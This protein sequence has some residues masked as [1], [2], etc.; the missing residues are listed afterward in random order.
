MSYTLDISLALGGSK[1]GL[2]LNAQLVDSSLAN[3]GSAISSGFYEVGNG[4]YLW[5]YS[6]FPDNFRG[7][8]KFYQQGQS[9]TILTFVSINPQDAENLDMKISNVSS[10]SGSG[11]EI[12]VNV[13][14]SNIVVENAS[15]TPVG[16]DQ[17]ITLT[18]GSESVEPDI[19]I[20]KNID[21]DSSSKITI[22]FGSENRDDSIQINSGV[23]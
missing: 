22:T 17:Y 4:Y 18:T 15:D 23:R 21:Q 13:G 11:N 20:S 1:T 12:N 7:G 3:V 19:V 8:V 16:N 5:H 6:A 2:T 9:S 10:G 14:H